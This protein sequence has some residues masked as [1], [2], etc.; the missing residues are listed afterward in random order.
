[1]ASNRVAFSFVKSLDYPMPS[2]FTR[3]INRE[4]PAKIF[5]ETDKVIVIQDIRPKAAVHLLIIPKAESKN[6]YETD[7]SVLS[8]LD[9]TVKTVA[10]K[11]GLEDRF[12]IQ[13]NNGLGQEVDHIHYHFMSDQNGDRV[14]FIKQ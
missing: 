10:K 4:L 12:R 8:L 14:T 11:L 2:I 9:D 3:I 5:Y 7:Q 13:V 1:M 6:F